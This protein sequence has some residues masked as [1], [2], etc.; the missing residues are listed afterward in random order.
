MEPLELA[1]KFLVDDLPGASTP[2]TRM[3]GVLTACLAGKPLSPHNESFLQ[4]RGLLV[5]VAFAKGEMGEDA[6]IQRAMAE[7]QS[8]KQQAEQRQLSLTRDAERAKAQREAAQ[9]AMWAEHEA[10][11]LRAERDPRNIARRKGRE[12]R[13]RFGIH[14]YVDP[15]LFSRLMQILTRLSGNSRLP[16]QDVAWL[17]GVGREFRTREVM[18]AYHRAEADHY[19]GTFKEKGNIWCAVSASSHLRKCGSFEEAHS[20]LSTV[21]H[22]RLV[23]AKLKSAFFTTHGGAL[24][25]LKRFQEAM[26]L[27]EQAHALADADYRPCTLLGAIHIELGQVAEGAAWYRKAEDRGAPAEHVDGELRSILARLPAKT[28]DMVVNELI[29]VDRVRYDW[30]RKKR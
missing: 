14:D 3:Q 7:Q 27:G 13:E 16:E 22:K 21:P 19:L 24:R 28:R 10:A 2:F 20:L 17:A 12:L 1:R 9:A 29:A 4:S 23:P 25:D 15:D 5:L 30:L 6:F 11:R 8:R 18:T 26:S